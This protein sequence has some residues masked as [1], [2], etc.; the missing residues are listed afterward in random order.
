MVKIENLQKN[1]RYIVNARI[2]TGNHE[3]WHLH[4]TESFKT[5][6]TDSYWPQMISNET[7]NV[8]FMP[9][10]DSKALIAKIAWQPTAG[11]IIRSHRNNRS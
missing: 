5:L 11:E 4:S 6:E 7:I 10:N 2:F 8:D 3:Y 9:Q 1:T